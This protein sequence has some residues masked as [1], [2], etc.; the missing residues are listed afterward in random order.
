MMVDV[1]VP[2][3]MN[4]EDD[5]D[6][7]EKRWHANFMAISA[8]LTAARSAGIAIAICKLKLARCSY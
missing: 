2:V 1:I 7:L 5:L 3:I 6:N 8:R 4:I